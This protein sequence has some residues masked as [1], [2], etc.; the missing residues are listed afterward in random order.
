MRPI[1][2]VSPRFTRFFGGQRMLVTENRPPG[3]GP[4]VLDSRFARPT[5]RHYSRLILERA[6][7]ASLPALSYTFL[8][9]PG[10]DISIHQRQPGSGYEF[11]EP[12]LLLDDRLRGAWLVFERRSDDSIRARVFRTFEGASAE[13]ST[14]LGLHD[15]GD[16]TMRELS[17]ASGEQ[18]ERQL[19][20]TFEGVD[21]TGA[22]A[23]VLAPVSVALHTASR[24]FSR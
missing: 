10:R 16:V 22:S 14:R 1:H 20:I 9:D 3:Q 2:L 21:A 19:Q 5:L 13:F 18:R 4:T 6:G 23:M 24:L 15:K 8:G 7:I 11:T 12:H 17:G